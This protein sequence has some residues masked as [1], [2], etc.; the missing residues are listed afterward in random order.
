MGAHKS[1]LFRAGAQK[2]HHYQNIHP[3]SCSWTELFKKTITL[4]NHYNIG[5]LH[6]PVVVGEDREHQ[7][8]EPELC[9]QQNLSQNFT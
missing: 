3:W 5:D 7:Q 8:Q 4:T 9:D 6:G 2:Q 1:H